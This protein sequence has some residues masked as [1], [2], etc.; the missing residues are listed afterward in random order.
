MVKRSMTE[1]CEREGGKRAKKRTKELRATKK[2]AR[3]LERNCKWKANEGGA[4]RD[5]NKME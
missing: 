2:D 3:L 1:F 5:G 4:G